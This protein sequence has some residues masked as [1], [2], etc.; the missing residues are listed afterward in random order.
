MKKNS[1]VARKS[2]KKEWGRG[3]NETKRTSRNGIQIGC[4]KKNNERK[5]AK[6]KGGDRHW[7]GERER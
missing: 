4:D 6:G 5:R 2:E 1:A 7:V 3:R